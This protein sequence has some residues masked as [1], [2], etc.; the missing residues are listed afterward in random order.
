MTTLNRR[1]LVRFLQLKLRTLYEQNKVAEANEVVDILN[2]IST[3]KYNQ[4]WAH[5][6]IPSLFL[7]FTGMLIALVLIGVMLEV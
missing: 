6:I 5:N 1:K 3:G 2:K 4:T 7:I